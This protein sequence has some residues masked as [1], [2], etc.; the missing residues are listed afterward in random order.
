MYKIIFILIVMAIFM[1]GCSIK[2]NIP[3]RNKIINNNELDTEYL[4]KNY[5]LIDR[6][7]TNTKQRWFIMILQISGFYSFTDEYVIDELLEECNGDIATNVTIDWKLIPLY[8]VS[9]YEVSTT[10]DIWIKK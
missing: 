3:I 1:T 9:Y 6:S 4:N 10:A 7:C 2:K 8:Y 5:V